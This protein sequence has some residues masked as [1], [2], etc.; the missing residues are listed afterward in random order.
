MNA[1]KQID[2]PRVRLLVVGGDS[3]SSYADR[4]KLMGLENTI[5]FAGNSN[6]IEEYYASSDIFVL[7]SSYEPFG[8]VVLEAMASGL[9]VIVSRAC[10]AAEIIENEKEGLLFNEGDSESFVSSLR[11]L[12]GTPESRTLISKAARKAAEKYTWNKM[13]EETEKVYTEILNE[14][15]GQ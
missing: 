6:K 10:G 1:I 15:A 8:L 4:V 7:P 5:I 13:G 12:I 3:H 11:R 14:R 2:D 9:P